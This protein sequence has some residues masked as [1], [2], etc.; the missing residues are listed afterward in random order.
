MTQTSIF[1]A[2]S[3]EGLSAARALTAHLSSSA[4]VALWTEGAFNANTRPSESLLDLANRAD[5]A[6]YVLCPDDFIT[7]RRSKSEVRANIYF[8]LG[9]LAGRLGQNRLFIVVLDPAKAQLPSDLAGILYFGVNTNASLDL[10][11]AV[12]PAADAIRREVTR[13]KSRL[14]EAYPY[15]SCFISY[16]WSDKEFARRLY[17]DLSEVGISCWLDAKDLQIGGKIAD[18]VER[19]IQSQDKVL[20][21]LSRASIRSA[22]VRHEFRHALKLEAER[23][24]TVLFPLSLD[25]SIFSNSAPTTLVPLRDR[26]ICDFSEWET[27]S[28]YKKAFAS[29]VRDLTIRSSV[30][31]GGAT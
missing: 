14:P 6:V 27:G 17:D 28:G 11:L 16:S 13:V 26:V 30:E 2:S 31:S 12:A 9:L 10:S 25:N 29:L 5:F 22:W 24:R 21:V 4:D 20:L 19:A 3:L 8:E 7:T 1:I 23:H 15:Y 18:Q